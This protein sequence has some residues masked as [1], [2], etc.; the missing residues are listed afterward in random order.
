MLAFFLGCHLKKRGDWWSCNLPM[1]LQDWLYI[2]CF[3]SQAITNNSK[4]GKVHFQLFTVQKD[5]TVSVYNKVSAGRLQEQS[6]K[7]YPPW[8]QGSQKPYFWCSELS[9][10]GFI[11][12]VLFMLFVDLL[13]MLVQSFLVQSKQD[14]HDCGHKYHLCFIQGVKYHELAVNHAASTKTLFDQKVSE[15]PLWETGAR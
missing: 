12:V 1:C 4:N 6:A 10:C 14:K 8:C 15:H 11:L 13:K 3:L 2:C 5:I 9:L 7:I